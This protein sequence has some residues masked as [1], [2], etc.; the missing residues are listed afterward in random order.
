MRIVW[1][2]A[3]ITAFDFFE[4]GL[5]LLCIALAV[6]R[7]SLFQGLFAAIEKQLVVYSK[8]SWLCALIS[9]FLP[10]TLRLLLLPVYPPPV[11]AVHDEYAYLLQSDTFTSGR[12]ANP[13]LKFPREFETIYI[14]ATP[15]YSSEYEPAQGFFLAVGQKLF[16]LPWAGVLLS[17]GLL[18]AVA[19]WAF[20]G[21]FPPQWAFL[22]A[23]LIGI[24]IG[25]L[26]YWMNSYWGGCVPGIGGSLTLGGLARLRGR[27]RM[28]DALS[29]ALGI[30]ILL[31]SRPLEGA[32]L[33]V[34]VAGFVLFCLVTRQIS[35]TSFLSHVAFP[36]LVVFVPATLFLGYY[37]QRVT[38]NPTQIPYLLYRARYSI[39]QGFYWQK[40]PVAKADMPID[41]EGEYRN[42]SI[43]RRR[44]ASPKGMLLATAGKLR[45]FWVFYIGILLSVVLIAVPFIWR[46][47]NMDIVFF[48]L[49]VIVVFENLTYFAYFPHYSSA[50][51]IAIFVVL[52][53]CLRRV[54]EW[55]SAGLFLSRSLPLACCLSLGIAMAGKLIEPLLSPSA[56]V[57]TKLW[58]S[59]YEHWRSRE[60]F[61]SRLEAEPGKQLVMIRYDPT[62]HTND[63]AWTFNG[64]NLETAKIVWARESSDSDENR[65]LM[66]HF[67]DRKVW[68]A[69]PDATPQRIIP[70]PMSR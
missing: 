56:T 49:L 6:V 61:V 19:Y 42:Q 29:I 5:A 15:S 35:V 7:P 36:M 67:S 59:Q 8:R 21:W 23:L 34:V 65:R 53:Q 16:G 14:F 12:L 28:W 39:P 33:A 4:L 68:L 24:E 9:F 63:N 57:M 58:S 46:A 10:I 30:F 17:M 62:T 1:G 32:L 43:Q 48:A 66:S 45:A 27:S 25:V 44:A 52:L 3:P 20:L 64:A 47:R 37:D 69:E 18:C 54:R 51:T 26:S 40:A 22:G 11:P 13:P 41:I 50:V 31:S 2:S 60:P 70:F 55:G 38:G